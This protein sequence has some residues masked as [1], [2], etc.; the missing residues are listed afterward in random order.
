MPALTFDIHLREP[1]LAGQGQHGEPNST[2]ALPFISGS[3]IRGALIARYQKMQGQA[4]DAGEAAVRALF[5]DGTVRYLHAYPTHPE[6]GRLLPTPRSWLGE[7]GALERPKDEQEEDP[8]T[9]YDASLAAPPK[10]GTYKTLKDPFCR[11]GTALD[12]ETGGPRIQVQV[13]NF[14]NDRN[15]KQE[16]HSGVYRY[17]ALAPEQL[18]SAAIVTEDEAAAPHL[19]TLR[20]LLGGRFWLGGSQTAG[21][22]LVEIENVQLDERWQEYVPS[23]SATGKVVVTCLSDVI[24]RDARGQATG[25]LGQA[26]GVAPLRA[27][28]TLRRVGGFNRKWGLPLPEE[29]AIEAGSVF[30]FAAEHRPRL[31]DLVAAGV[32]ERRAEGFGRIAVDWQGAST[33]ERLPFSVAAPPR[34]APPL[35]DESEKLPLTDKSKQLLEQMVQRQVQSAMNRYLVEEIHRLTAEPERAF[36]DLPSPT[37]LSRA[38]LAARK[39][40]HTKNLKPLHDFFTQMTPLTERQWQNARLKNDPLRTWIQ[41]ELNKGDTFD[42]PE[43]YRPRTI[44]G[45]PLNLTEEMKTQAVARLIEGVLRRAVRHAK[46]KAE[47]E[48]R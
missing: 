10:G 21:Y 20:S 32:G 35:T 36:R 17:D 37:Q 19:A 44:A 2:I 40:W 9:L 48:G 4:L 13:H 45:Q 18:F 33:L 31:A 14:S 1:V 47:Q 7:K 46:E 27:F 30:V 41:D 8:I 15:R 16:R 3:M 43:E 26:V 11:L 29:W 24:V 25:D 6:G 12:V 34:V 22:G 39:A 42:L 38:R 28:Y 5:F 23:A